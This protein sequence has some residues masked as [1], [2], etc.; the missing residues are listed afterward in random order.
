MSLVDRVTNEMKGAM[1][2]RDKQRTSAL[3]M[4]R[5]GII[6]LDKAGKGGV[7]DDDVVKLLRKLLKQRTDAAQQYEGAG[8]PELAEGERFEAAVIEEF[9]PKLADE[10]T[11]RAWAEA[12]IAASGATE[13]RQL[14]M[15]MGALM[16]AHRGEV[17]GGLARRILSELL[18]G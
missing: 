16:K 11:T 5:A 1:K 18:G 6:E 9:L 4:L 8:R 17:D 2:A 13:P 15:A 7:S 14:G 12:A 10:A 3:R